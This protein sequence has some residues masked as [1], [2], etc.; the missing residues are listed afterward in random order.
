MPRRDRRPKT[1][2]RCNEPL[3][4]QQPK[5]LA[6]LVT[7]DGRHNHPLFSFGLMD[8]AYDGAWGW[9][10][11]NDTDARRLLD[12]MCE[13][14]RLTWQ[15]IRTQTASGH[16]RHHSQGVDSLC[17]DAKKRIVDLSLDDM[18][19]EVFRFRL[20][21]TARLWGFELGDGIFHALW[22]DP[23]HRVCPLEKAH[24]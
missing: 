18:G 19:E 22:W 3:G 9:H 4:P 8:R 5:A 20:D 11:L 14:A 6:A 24:T 17:P 2:K 12:L 13:M 1:D 10:L 15:D 23:N 21:G 7:E 16:L